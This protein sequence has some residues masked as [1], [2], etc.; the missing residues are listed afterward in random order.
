MLSA[1]Q[2]QSES[3]MTK[4]QDFKNRFVAVLKDLQRSGSKD[5]EAMWLLGSLASDLADDLKRSSWTSA[6]NAMG[7]KTFDALLRKF[8]EQGNEH[9]REGRRKH[10]Y[11]IQ[12]LSMSLVAR[13]QRNDPQMAEGEV[14]LDRM[15]DY[16]TAVYRKAKAAPPK[17]N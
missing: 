4:E 1:R 13:T 17:P 8:E 6:K 11:A 5:G 12:T 16:A 10:A 15:I 7:P 3:C 9:H 2:Y 14:L